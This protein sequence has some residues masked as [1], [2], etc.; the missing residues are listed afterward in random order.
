MFNILK[1]LVRLYQVISTKQILNPP[2]NVLNSLTKKRLPEAVLSESSNKR[3]NV[4]I[5][6]LSYLY[7]WLKFESITKM[8]D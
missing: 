2:I 7:D 4:P 1:K 8:Q 6:T 5:K 3:C